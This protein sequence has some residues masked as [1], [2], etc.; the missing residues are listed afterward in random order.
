MTLDQYALA[1]ATADAG[2]SLCTSQV[3]NL[4]LVDVSAGWLHIDDRKIPLADPVRERIAAYLDYRTATRP[5]I[6]EPHLLINPGRT[7]ESRNVGIRA[8]AMAST[9]DAKRLLNMF[10]LSISARLR[11]AD[12]V[13]HPGFTDAAPST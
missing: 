2:D 4:R 6:A 13:G 1:L 12:V 5:N 9:G 11:Y 10:G 8:E 3:R 7:L